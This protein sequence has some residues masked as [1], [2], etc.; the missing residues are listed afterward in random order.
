VRKQLTAPL[1][2]REPTPQTGRKEINDTIIP[3]LALRITSDGTRSFA[4][5][6]RINEKQVRITIGDARVLKLVDARQEASDILKKC[7]A[8]IDPREEKRIERVTAEKEDALRFSVVADQFIE[9]YCKKRTRGWKQTKS[10]LDRD[11]I[12]RWKNRLLTEINRDDI[13]AALD[14]IEDRASFVRANRALAVIRKL[15]NWAVAERGMLA[16]SPIVICFL[17]LVRDAARSQLWRLMHSTPSME[18]PGPSRQARLRQSVHMQ[19]RCQI[20]PSK[21][22]HR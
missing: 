5:R 9:R 12:P 20:L 22:W 21:F 11:F 2:E 14:A 1:I 19:Y 15:F 6:T 3:Q 18:E 7:K 10:T 17:S 13:A 4:L 8:G 16:I